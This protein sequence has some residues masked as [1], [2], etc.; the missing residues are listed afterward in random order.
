MHELID[1][2]FSRF[3]G[4]HS[5]PKTKEG[6]AF[7]WYG[8][9]I[10]I[11]YLLRL[12]NSASIRHKIALP[13][14]HPTSFPT[15]CPGHCSN[16][17]NTSAGSLWNSDGFRLHI[18]WPFAK[19]FNFSFITIFLF[20]RTSRPLHS[21]TNA[22]SL[23]RVGSASFEAIVS[24]GASCIPRGQW[25]LVR[26][27]DLGIDSPSPTVHWPVMMPL[28]TTL[29]QSQRRNPSTPPLIETTK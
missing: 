19:R 5:P 24:I 12:E 4:N 20:W 22:I 28:R 16:K 3:P 21:L 8:K 7:I 25:G 29:D 9:T 13:S 23:K 27:L 1:S 18:I 2:T 11:I 6:I 15:I 10:H 14:N 26:L 17:D